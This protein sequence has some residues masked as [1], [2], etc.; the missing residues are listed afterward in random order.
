MTRP[1][2]EDHHVHSTFSDGTSS[3]EENI[4]AAERAG[5]VHLGCVDHVRADTQYVP[6]YAAAVNNLRDGT[7]VTLSI[8]IEAKMLDASGRLDLPADGLSDVER[9]Y[10]ADHV[11]PS[12]EGPVSPRAIKEAIQR[13]DTHV[14]ACIATLVAAITS[15][16]RENRSHPLVL[17][18]PFSI[19]PKMG[20][21]EDQVP[22]HLLGMV[23]DAAKETGTMVE[24]SEKWRCPS[25]RTL[26]AMRAAGVMLVSGT[27]SHAAK[28]IG[29]YDYVR[30]MLQELAA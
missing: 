11:F 18:H 15:A 25:L 13:G 22:D 16:L 9:V 8:G 29:R 10:V 12:R 21:S 24:I 17:A 6:S 19:L 20:L 4:A 2:L 7:T 5:L 1:L 30:S 3:L 14:T 23:A 27:D 28:T 26:R